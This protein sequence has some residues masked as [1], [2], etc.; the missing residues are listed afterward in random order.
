[1]SKFYQRG[2]TAV[3]ILVVVTIIGILVTVALPQFSKMKENQVFKNAV[4]DII[5]ALHNAQSQSLASTNFSE[6]GIHFQSDQI[7]IFKGK[8]FS[9]G[10]QGNN[11]I[12]INSP[13]SISNVTL[14]GV[15]STSGDVYFK[16]LSGVPDKTGTI[17]VSTLSYSKV[18][19]IS[20]PGAISV[21]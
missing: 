17:T 12:N 4:E 13:A 5:S 10:A 3:E 11:I 16:R 6:Y 19:M 18:I 8:T 7:I 14:A 2:I 9:L 21:N 20:A 15:S 1:M